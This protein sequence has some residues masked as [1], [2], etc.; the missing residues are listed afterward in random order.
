MKP[1]PGGTPKE[2]K[3]YCT[4]TFD[5]DKPDTVVINIGTNRIGKLEASEIAKDIG[6]IVTVA[7]NHGVNKVFVS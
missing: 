7:H 4:Y 6:E 2:L 5:N 3:H 1:Y